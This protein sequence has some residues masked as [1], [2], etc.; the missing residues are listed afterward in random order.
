MRPVNVDD[1]FEARQK[2]E[3]MLKRLLHDAGPREVVPEEDLTAIKRAALGR[4]NE[5]VVSEQRR[6]RRG[7][8]QLTLASAAGLTIAVLLLALWWNRPQTVPGESLATVELVSGRVLI[9]NGTNERPIT[10]SDGLFAGDVIRT[11]GGSDS[12]GRIALRLDSGH[13]ARLD[14]GTAVEIGA[15][16]LILRQGAV[17][18]DSGAAMLRPI[19]VVTDWGV[20]REL[21]TQYEVRVDDEGQALRVRVRE[22]EVGVQAGAAVQT[23]APG[24]ELVID[25]YGSGTRNT[26]PLFGNGWDWV[27]E[28]APP[29]GLDGAT[30]SDFL[31]WFSGETG[32][33]ASFA[34]PA[35]EQRVQEIKIHGDVTGMSPH[36]ALEVVLAGSG[37]GH[38][39]EGGEIFVEQR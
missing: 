24:E 14:N 38:R 13:S 15:D 39:I 33:I 11:V 23:V 25:R 31:S 16:S 10:A 35:L 18:V 30:V 20:V 19:E 3:Q 1:S 2:D 7:R 4:W 32:L 29:V 34:D 27:L 9:A 6:A 28:I 36:Q 37:L 22:G 5:V 12:A 17:Y 26:I 8:W 21:G